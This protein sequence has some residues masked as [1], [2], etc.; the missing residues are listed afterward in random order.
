M[1]N[2]TKRKKN[3][4]FLFFS[5]IRTNKM[6]FETFQTYKAQTHIIDIENI[7]IIKYLT[8]IIFESIR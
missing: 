2:T 8:K 7:Y 3:K 1:K 5:L 6:E 4:Y